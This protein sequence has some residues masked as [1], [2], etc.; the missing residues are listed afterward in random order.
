MIIGLDFDNT[1]VS[2]DDLLHQTAVQRGLIDPATPKTK[3]IVRDL[4]RQCDEGDIG[5]QR[6]Q[7]LVYG[8]LMPHA[9]LIPGVREFVGI[10][11]R[12]RI[13]VF[14]VS[15]KTEYAGYD[16]SRTN[17][18]TAS[19]D[20]MAQHGFF[21]PA[22]LAFDRADVFFEPTRGNKIARIISL[23]CTHFVD[24]LEEVLC[25]PLFPADVQRLLFNPAATA[26]LTADPVVIDRWE[27]LSELVAS[28]LR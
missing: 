19:L 14:I 5:W 22:G 11:R 4:V 20:W 7:G 18:R 13:P 8:P 16:D 21:D 6:I 3:R 2:Y 28:Q 1:I 15:H 17:L 27:T 10:C 23:G 26:N 9:Q 25:D 24:D 12:L